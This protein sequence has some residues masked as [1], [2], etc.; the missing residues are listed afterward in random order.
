M[1]SRK[2]ISEVN[3]IEAQSEKDFEEF[4]ESLKQV[5]KTVGYRTAIPTQLVFV[6]FYSVLFA[7][8]P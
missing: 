7:L 3:D 6:S 4:Q 1:W 2:I 8:W 5:H